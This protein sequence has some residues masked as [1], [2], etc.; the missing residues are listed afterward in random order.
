MTD[1]TSLAARDVWARHAN[2]G[3]VW[4]LLVSYP[5][6]IAGLYRRDRALV[7][8]VLAFV[9]ANPLL[10]DPP[11]DDDAWATRV[12]LGERLWLAE[13]VRSSPDVAA[14]MALG[15]PLNLFTLR[16]AAA[17]RP[18][19]TVVGTVASLG[20]SLLCFHRLVRYYDAHDDRRSR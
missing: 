9:A 3:S 7:C 14:L 20:L 5:L 18:V 4:T 2:P 8:A 17:R 13:G 12:V 10:F 11:D 19:R 1:T 15:A 16:A 6:L